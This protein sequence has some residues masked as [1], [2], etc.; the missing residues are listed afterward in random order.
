MSTGLSPN[1]EA[2]RRGQNFLQTLYDP[3]TFIYP[4]DQPAFTGEDCWWHFV[5]PFIEPGTLDDGFV[6]DAVTR[7]A[8]R[9]VARLAE[10]EPALMV[11]GLRVDPSYVEFLSHG[12]YEHRRRVR[13]RL[14]AAMAKAY[15]RATGRKLHWERAWSAALMEPDALVRGLTHLDLPTSPPMTPPM[16]GQSYDE[17]MERLMAS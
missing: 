3:E 11:R 12:H 8:E 7:A 10:G 2:W 4:V 9:A 13:A 1:P 5:V 6:R 17:F 14:G 16:V 15:R